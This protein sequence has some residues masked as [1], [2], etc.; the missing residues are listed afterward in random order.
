MKIQT[1]LEDIIPTRQNVTLN[2]NLDGDK[3]PDPRNKIGSG[4]FSVARPDR[5]PHMIKKYNHNF[6]DHDPFNDY[7]EYIV[8]HKLTGNPYFPRVYNIKTVSD[9]NG[10]Q[11]H[12][13]TIEKLISAKELEPEEVS[14]LIERTFTD[15][16]A[17]DIIETSSEPDNIRFYHNSETYSLH[18][19]WVQNIHSAI[20]Y[21][22][23]SNITDE[24]LSEAVKVI[25]DMIKNL[26]FA[27]DLHANNVM[28]RRTK[29][30]VQP[31]I[32]DPLA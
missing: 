15:M 16:V 27:N 14:T 29:Y 31:V 6:E 20:E 5:D 2:R 22:D 7:V 19:T 1:I 23:T 21:G 17:K 4:H 25:H 9:P 28:Y 30:G 18:S 8:E 3:V 12:K 32:S 10:Q 24:N 11:S 13:Y 26:K